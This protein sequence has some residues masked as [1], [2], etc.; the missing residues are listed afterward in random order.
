MHCKNFEPK[1][2]STLRL[3]AIDIGSN[4]ALLSIVEFEKNGKYRILYEAIETPRIG[5]GLEKNKII[6]NQRIVNLIATLKRFQSSCYKFSTD[7]ILIAGTEALRKAKNKQHVLKRVAR[8]TNFT[9][10]V[11][12]AKEEAYLSYISATEELENLGKEQYLVIDIGAGSIE[13]ISQKA[14][15]KFQSQSVKLGVLRIKELFDLKY[16]ASELKIKNLQEFIFLKF[17]KLPPLKRF[18]KAIGVGGT[19]TTVAALKNKKIKY[20]NENLDFYQISENT[21]KQIIKEIR[22]K[23]LLRLRQMKGMPKGRED[24]LLPGLIMIEQLFRLQKIDNLIVRNR[25]VRFGLLFEYCKN[26]NPEAKIEL[27]QVAVKN[28]RHVRIPL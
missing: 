13:L 25:G 2:S 4:S 23:N 27:S 7:K 14:K 16:P 17:K 9:I 20:S 11:I 12:S 15:G 26:L 8:A 18:R 19:F 3:A 5:K 6:S 1:N 24:V 10:R 22:P 21:I 28:D